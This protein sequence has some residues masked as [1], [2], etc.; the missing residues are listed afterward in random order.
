MQVPWGNRARAAV[1]EGD[2]IAMK[3][4]SVLLSVSFPAALTHL[5]SASSHHLPC[6]SAPSPPDPAGAVSAG[7]RWARTCLQPPREVIPGGCGWPIARCWW[8]A[9]RAPLSQLNRSV[10]VS[11]VHLSAAAYTPLPLTA[12]G[13]WDCVAVGALERRDP[14]PSSVPSI[15]VSSHAHQCPGYGTPHLCWGITG[16]CKPSHGWA[17]PHSLG[18]DSSKVVDCGVPSLSP[19]LTPAPPCPPGHRSLSR[20]RLISTTHR[21]VWIGAA[22]SIFLSSHTPALGSPIASQQRA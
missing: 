12:F 13:G 9:P 2:P 22:N 19:R 17:F 16:E 11:Q 3:S 15:A 18:K 4:L 6:S 20:P 21:H 8:S 5:H 14:V 1:T 7:Q 10:P